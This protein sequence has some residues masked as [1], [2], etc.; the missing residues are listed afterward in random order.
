MQIERVK[1]L[2]LIYSYLHC[3]E[4]KVM[5]AIDTKICTEVPIVGGSAADNQVSGN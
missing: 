3:N 5:A 2:D 1:Y 4:E